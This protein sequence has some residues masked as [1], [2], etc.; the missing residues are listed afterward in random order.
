MK[1]NSFRVLAML[2]MVL[3]F[4]L[5]LSGCATNVASGKPPKWDLKP[6]AVSGRDYT[7]LGNVK[8]EKNWFGVLGVSISNNMIAMDAYVYQS[9][10][11]TYADLLEE[12]QKK[13]PEAD[14]VIDVTVDYSGSTYAIFYAQRKNI[15]TGI[16][17]SYVKTPSK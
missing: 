5:G 13:F 4:G 3:V 8:L 15:V 11:V 12:A 9:G 1:K 16:A 17:V 14:A 2:V 6:I 7:I 10:G